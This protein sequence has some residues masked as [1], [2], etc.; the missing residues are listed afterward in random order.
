MYSAGGRSEQNGLIVFLMSHFSTE[1][2]REQ[3]VVCIGPLVLVADVPF[4]VKE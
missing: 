1:T 3:H 2:Q 4:V